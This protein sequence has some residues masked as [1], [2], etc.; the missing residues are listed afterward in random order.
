ME[1]DGNGQARRWCFTWNNPDCLLDYWFQQLSI[2]YLVYQEEIGESGTYHLQGYVEF[3]RATRLQ[4]LKN[5][6][7]QSIHFEI[8]RGTAADNRDYCTKAESRIGGPYESGQS[9]GQGKR[10]DIHSFYAAIKDGKTDQDLFE[11][12]TASMFR[13][14][15]VVP[16]VRELQYPPRDFKS[17]VIV[18][19]GPPGT[20]K[21]S[22]CQANSP[23][24]YWKSPDSE[25]WD[26]YNGQ[27]DVVLD[28]FSGWIKYSSF[29]RILDR[30][31]LKV[32]AK[33]THINYCPKRIFIT[34]NKRS[35]Q[36]YKPSLDF[37]AIKR[38]IDK[39][40]VMP[41][42]GT[43]HHLDNWDDFESFLPPKSLPRIR[44][45]EVIGP[46]GYGL[47]MDDA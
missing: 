31:P 40:I 23:E 45:P 14:V 17:E 18:I 2:S 28:D 20:G 42:L 46:G 3:A 26:G 38:R 7:G 6:L 30:Y 29:L 11:T 22:Y 1:Q 13:Y 4:T 33:G 41:E 43:V 39:F 15:K 5:K 10:T 47:H 32:Q 27:T 9:I 25:W 21:S 19:W 35:D 12:H 24:A 44:G 34:C 16:M 37:T 8:A 36:W